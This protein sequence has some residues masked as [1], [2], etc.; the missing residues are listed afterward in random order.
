MQNIRFMNNSGGNWKCPNCDTHNTGRRCVVCGE[1]KQI[2]YLCPQQ[3]GLKSTISEKNKINKRIFI[4]TGASVVILM[5]VVISVA[6]LLRNEEQPHKAKEDV[7]VPIK[8]EEI[9]KEPKTLC[10]FV[11]GKNLSLS[12]DLNE[13][14]VNPNFEEISNENITY[15]YPKNFE[16]AGENR[17]MAVD[18]T[19]YIC[20]GYDK[21][22][23]GET[24][25]S[26]L[27][28]RKAVL[29]N[30]VDFEELIDGR[31]V[32]SLKKD[33]IFYCEKGMISDERTVRFTF[34]CP[35]QYKNVYDTYINVL[36]EG[37]KLPD[38]SGV[39]VIEE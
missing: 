8:A 38:T 1:K 27:K 17:Y 3:G 6:S 30:N 19:A 2:L 18:K 33:G 34:I 29:G 35:S 39:E 25:E 4:W 14:N 15:V 11:F 10:D 37:L 5:L 36:E 7:T 16:N 31:Y 28:K 21:T 20:Y 23:D 12:I 9:K 26:V 13:I 22:D 24:A 32:I